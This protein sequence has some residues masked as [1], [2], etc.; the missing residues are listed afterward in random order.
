[1]CNTQSILQRKTH[2]SCQ[3]YVSIFKGHKHCEFKVAPRIKYYSSL[4]DFKRLLRAFYFTGGD[5]NV[6]I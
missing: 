4:T 2:V 1:M 3:R 6:I 5:K